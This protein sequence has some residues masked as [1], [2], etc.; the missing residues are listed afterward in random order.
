MRATAAAVVFAV[1]A[2]AAVVAVFAV[3]AVVAV[4]IIIIVLPTCSSDNAF[5]DYH[6]NYYCDY[7]N[8]YG[9]NDHQRQSTNSGDVVLFFTATTAKCATMKRLR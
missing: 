2:A 7:Y 4:I 6:K 3:V 9:Q 1:V 8:C 5:S